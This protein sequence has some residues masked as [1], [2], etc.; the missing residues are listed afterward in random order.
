[1][2]PDGVGHDTPET[3]GNG[4]GSTLPPARFCF[5]QAI[6]A[7][8]WD[9][10]REG[11]FSEPYNSGPGSTIMPK[12]ATVLPPREPDS[13]LLLKMGLAK[14]VCL[15]MVVAVVAANVAGALIPALGRS[16]PAGW[17]MMK[18]ESALV[19]FLS[20]ASLKLSETERTKPMHRLSLALAALVTVLAV[21]ALFECGFHLSQGIAGLYSYNPASWSSFRGGISPL[22]ACGFTLLGITMLLARAQRRFTIRLA[23][24]LAAGLCLAVL[25]LV[26]GYI[27]DT[28]EIYGAATRISASPQ[29]LFCLLLLTVAAMLRRSEGGIFSIFIGDGIGSKIARILSPILLVLPFLREA[30]RAQIVGGSRMP[31]YY[32]TTM[33]SSLTVFLA[34]GLL[35]YLAR[36]LNG[37]EMEIHGLTLRDELTGLYNLKGFRLLAEQALRLA[38]RSDLPFSVLYIDLDGLKLINDS[39]GHTTG[40]AFLAEMGELLHEIFRETDV[41]GRIGGDEF[42]VAGQFDEPEIAQATQRLQQSCAQRNIEDKRRFALSFSVG[43]AT[44]DDGRQEALDELLTRAD[45]AMYADKRRKKALASQD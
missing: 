41:L 16:F 22:A 8:N 2:K 21:A 7:V 29:T 23:D 1:M 4:P 13:S 42:A 14:R 9:R 39:L 32:A 12:L 10:N 40:S 45:R 25:V 43:H 19:A 34:F 11:P 5:R 31:T 30:A 6:L 18:A 15:V 26:S 44:S 3:P 33:M 24:L 35:L 28:L 38:Y 37:M 20:A 27:F 36:R 17:P